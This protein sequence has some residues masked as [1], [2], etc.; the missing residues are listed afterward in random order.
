V[1]E[2]DF[3]TLSGH[4]AIVGR[5]EINGEC[6]GATVFCV[7]LADGFILECGSS[8]YAEP[9]AKA[10]ADAINATGPEKFDFRKVRP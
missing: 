5:R 3:A 4:K 9:R 1:S 8:G 10:I 6:G 7:V 2:I